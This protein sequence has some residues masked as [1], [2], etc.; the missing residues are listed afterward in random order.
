MTSHHCGA[1]SN[2]SG[3][4]HDHHGHSHASS[5]EKLAVATSEEVA[6]CP[7]MEGTPVIKAEAEEAGLYRDYQGK[8]YWLCCEGCGPLFDA[9]PEEYATSA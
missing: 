7:V 4:N 3:N 2:N 9:A 1:H 8:R 5:P 6:E